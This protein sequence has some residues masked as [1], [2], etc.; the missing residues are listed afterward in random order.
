MTFL[1][2]GVVKKKGTNIST[3]W[4]E[5]VIWISDLFFHPLQ[6]LHIKCHQL[7]NNSFFCCHSMMYTWWKFTSMKLRQP[8]L[9]T[10]AVIF[11]PFLMSC[12]LTHF[13]MAEL[14]CLASTPLQKGNKRNINTFNL[15][16]KVQNT[17]KEV[18]VACIH[19]F[20][21][22]GSG[23]HTFSRT[24][25]LAWEAPPK[26]LAFRAV[27]KWAFLYCLSCHFCSRRWLRSF[28]AVRR[29]R[30]FPR[31]QRWAG[32]KSDHCLVVV[33]K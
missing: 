3:G 11:L 6:I 1:W 22:S 17:W 29:P 32:I 5:L 8:S 25:P 18:S 4:F 10:K 24:M 27:P 30:H 7:H 12:T 13:L 19:V 16:K 20:Y 21:R 23:T 2:K 31:R 14:G 9:G 28:L 26:G 33:L 15:K